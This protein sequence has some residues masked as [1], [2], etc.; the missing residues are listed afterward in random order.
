MPEL[1]HA[2]QTTKKSN[3]I[4]P[5][6]PAHGD[7]G[8]DKDKESS[9]PRNRQTPAK[10]QRTT[11][12]HCMQDARENR[13]SLPAKTLVAQGAEA[14][15]WEMEYMGRR[16]IVKSRIAKP[17]RHPQLDAQLRSRRLTQE[18]RVLLRLRKAG[19]PVPAV[20]EL[21]TRRASLTMQF[22]RGDTLK[23]YLHDAAGS[24][25]R[26]PAV[27]ALMALTGHMVARMHLLAI[28]HGDLTT[29]NLLVDPGESDASPTL[30]LIDFGL[31]FS[32]GTDE[33]LAVDLYVF[34]RAVISAHSEFAHTLNGAF[35]T[36]YADT[37]KRPQVI[38][39]LDQVRARGRKRDMTG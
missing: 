24:P 7:D 15:V 23:V 17:Y 21:D 20:Y 10:R 27:V 6:P 28:V 3:C 32:N 38:A 34:E 26:R 18:A 14:I 5:P 35:L 39:R 19:I 13:V 8:D 36:S 4:R 33:D 16:A 2:P 12:P 30:W 37:L 25:Q 9:D 22:V 1:D 11:S 31:S 29:S